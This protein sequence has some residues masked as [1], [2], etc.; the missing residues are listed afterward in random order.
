MLLT[1]IYQTDFELSSYKTC[2]LFD[3]RFGHRALIIASQSLG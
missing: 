3:S 1:I 2:H